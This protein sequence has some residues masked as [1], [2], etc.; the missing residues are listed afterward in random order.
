MPATDSL[1][2]P[3]VVPFQYE[4][5]T[6]NVPAQVDQPQIVVRQGESGVQILETER[7]ASPLSDEVRSALRHHL[8][9]QM[10]RADSAGVARDSGLQN[11]SIQVDIRRLEMVPGHYA[12]IEAIWSLRN[13]RGAGPRRSLS[14]TSVIRQE[15][16]A[17]MSALVLAHQQLIRELSVRIVQTV[18]PWMASSDYACPN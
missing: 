17:E 18:I 9:L 16:T 3:T 11:A 7:W 4:L 1:I 6:V 5:T 12:L 14:C 2:T 8:R 15:A 10:G 13:T